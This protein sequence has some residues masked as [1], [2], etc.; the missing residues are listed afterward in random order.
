MTFTLAQ[1]EEAIRGS[2]SEDTASEDNEWT[3]DNPSCGQCDITTL[4][5]HDLLGGE[6]LAA[7]V[8]LDGE[9]VEAHMWN[10]L[11]SGLEVDLTREQFRSGQVIGEPRVGKRPATFDPAHPRYHRYEQ[12]LVLSE[13]VRTTLGLSVSDTGRLPQAGVASGA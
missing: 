12:Y 3:P 4:V 11:P 10:R 5:V 13:R 6:V 1:L 9:R 8:F 2:W 7:D